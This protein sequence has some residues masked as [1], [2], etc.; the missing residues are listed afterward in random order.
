MFKKYNK[1]IIITFCFLYSQTPVFDSPYLTE[2]IRKNTKKLLQFDKIATNIKDDDKIERLKKQVKFYRAISEAIN[3]ELTKLD[4]K[5]SKKFEK[6]EDLIL[7]YK[8]KINVAFDEIK[9]NDYPDISYEYKPMKITSKAVQKQNHKK[10]AMLMKKNYYTMFKYY[11]DNTKIFTEYLQYLKEIKETSES[12]KEFIANKNDKNE[13]EKPIP[14]D[15]KVI[16]VSN[17]STKDDLQSDVAVKNDVNNENQQNNIKSTQVASELNKLNEEL[18]YRIQSLEVRVD[19][20]AEEENKKDDDIISKVDK[21]ED[22]IKSLESNN[23]KVNSTLNSINDNL[24]TNLIQNKD[25]F[26]SFTN[27]KNNSISEFTYRGKKIFV[28]TRKE[29]KES[30]MEAR[31]YGKE[32][33]QIGDEKFS[34]I[35]EYENIDR[36]IK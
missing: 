26:E 18:S 10:Q 4:N 11:K 3:I 13:S 1:L 2:D 27:S 14:K 17:L 5:N 23:K 20:M 19:E 15:D 8:N 30:L 34:P 22:K 16:A 29:Y 32:N 7:Q 28:M 25:F 35:L 21:I 31:I 24:N 12:N 33:F 9:L 36:L 6:F